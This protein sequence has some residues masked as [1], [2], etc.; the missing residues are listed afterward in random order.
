MHNASFLQISFQF[1]VKFSKKKFW[2]QL[3]LLF[4]SNDQINVKKFIIKPGLKITKTYIVHCSALLEVETE[5]I[6]N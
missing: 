5:T 4:T 3:L 1:W 2:Y 6:I